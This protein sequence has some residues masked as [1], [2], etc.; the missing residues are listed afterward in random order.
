MICLWC[1]MPLEIPWPMSIEVSW[2]RS[3]ACPLH[4]WL[5]LGDKIRCP[6]D[7]KDWKDWM[8][9]I[10][11]H[12][13]FGQHRGSQISEMLIRASWRPLLRKGV[14]ASSCCPALA[15]WFFSETV[16]FLSIQKK[17][18]VGRSKVRKSSGFFP[19]SAFFGS[20]LNFRLNWPALPTYCSQDVNFYP[21]P[22]SR[23]NALSSGLSGSD[24]AA[25]GFEFGDVP[26]PLRHGH[27]HVFAQQGWTTSHSFCVTWSSFAM[28]C[29]WLGP[30]WTSLQPGHAQGISRDFG[31]LCSQ[32]CPSMKGRDIGWHWEIWGKMQRKHIVLD[33]IEN[34]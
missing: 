23:P 8:T 32:A 18:P 24:F 9:N 30:S 12:G 13:T 28:I 29:L 26:R 16:F 20:C 1:T 27:S 4:P 17:K 22:P 33:A 5:C 15:H 6:K 14:Q 10:K 21:T 2:T 19:C 11:Y 7:L 34:D 3:G 31:S 25:M